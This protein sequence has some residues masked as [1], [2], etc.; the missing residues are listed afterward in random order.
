MRRSSHIRVGGEFIAYK[1]NLKRVLEAN[2]G[3]SFSD[4]EVTNI[5]ARLDKK[6]RVIRLGKDYVVQI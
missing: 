1:N 3:R 2:T 4:A 5:I 6:R